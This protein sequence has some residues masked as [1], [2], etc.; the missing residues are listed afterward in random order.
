M[1]YLPFHLSPN[2][3]FHPQAPQTM[4]ISY[5]IVFA[6]R[7]PTSGIQFPI[8]RIQSKC[9]PVR[10]LKHT[11]KNDSNMIYHKHNHYKSAPFT[12]AVRHDTSQNEDIAHDY[13]GDILFLK[14]A[15]MADE[16]A[17]VGVFGEA[18]PPARHI[19]RAHTF[20]NGN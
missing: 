6:L 16:S 14:C 1:Y 3:H 19:T 5:A 18:P 8:S 11:H 15:D 12:W 7:L 9:S 20:Q 4:I 2:Y 13:P 10:Q 17:S